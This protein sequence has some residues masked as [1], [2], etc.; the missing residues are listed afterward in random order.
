MPVVTLEV[1]NTMRG[2]PSHGFLFM[3]VFQ[4]CHT[5]ILDFRETPPVRSQEA[6]IDIGL[7]KRGMLICSL[8]SLMY[9]MDSLAWADLKSIMVLLKNA[10]QKRS[11]RD[12][13]WML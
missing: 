10:G 11:S 7:A 13:C 2:E 1:M 6:R 4:H 5:A 9:D 8:N 12:Q 3:L